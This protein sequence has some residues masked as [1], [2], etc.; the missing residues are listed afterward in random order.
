MRDK[1]LK[2]SISSYFSSVINIFFIVTVELIISLHVI[3][4]KKFLQI[5]RAV[6]VVKHLHLNIVNILTNFKFETQ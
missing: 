5:T 1:I 6:L 3:M 2:C 4:I